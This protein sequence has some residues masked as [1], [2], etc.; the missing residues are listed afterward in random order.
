MEINRTL[1]AAVLRIARVAYANTDVRL[2]RGFFIDGLF[3][4][5]RRADGRRPFF[6]RILFCFF[7][8][9]L[10]LFTVTLKITIR[11]DVLIVESL[12]SRPMRRKKTFFSSFHRCNI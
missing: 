12:D 4:A 6:K 10:L 3:C 9:L 8:F 7:F 11:F 2:I 1:Y 5:V